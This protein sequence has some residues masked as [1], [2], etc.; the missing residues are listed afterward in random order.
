MLDENKKGTRGHCLKLRKI[1]CTTWSDVD[2]TLAPS[3]SGSLWAKPGCYGC[4]AWQ[5]VVKIERSVLTTIDE[6][7]MLCF[8]TRDI[9]RHFLNRVV[10]RWNLL[11]QRTVDAR[12]LNVF[13]NG[14]SRIRD[15]RMASSW[16]RSAK[17]RPR[18][19]WARREAAQGKSRGRWYDIYRA[20]R[21]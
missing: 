11:D 9:T 21:S 6:D 3:V 1:R 15:N 20:L 5:I 8:V 18:W 17:P 7:V 10:N 13:K 14:L 12:S 16:T 19:G 4:P 2:N